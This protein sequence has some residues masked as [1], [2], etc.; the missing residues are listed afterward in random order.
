[1][2]LNFWAAS[3]W[4]KKKI[5]LLLLIAALAAGVLAAAESRYAAFRL[6]DITAVPPAIL[7]ENAVWGTI[8]PEQEKCWFL[9]W[10]SKN[11][12]CRLIENYYPVSLNLRLSG[13]GK[14]D[15][16]ITPL[17]P[18]FKMYW[19]GRFWYVSAD[20]RVW[21]VSLHENSFIS[22]DKA[23]SVPVLSWS[24][25]RTTPLEISGKHGNIYSSSLPMERITKWYDNVKALGWHK[26]VKYIEAGVKEGKKVVRLIFYNEAGDNGV[27]MLFDDDPE[28]WQEA[29]LAVKKIYPDIS[30]ISPDVFIDT[31]YKGKILVKNK[32][33]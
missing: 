16:E 9:F 26:K 10:L 30:S 12:Y 23:N 28:L 6:L 15:L 17:V 21:L 18:A 8:P 5:K 25:D 2:K 1:M 4:S 22:A 11:S 3:A 27:N 19:G 7:P 20:A 31:T 24:S 29:G 13:W 32:V 14:F 33:Q